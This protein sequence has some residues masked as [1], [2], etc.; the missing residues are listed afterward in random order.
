MRNQF[1]FFDFKFGKNIKFFKVKADKN[2]KS[3]FRLNRFFFVDM[4]FFRVLQNNRFFS[5]LSLNL[6]P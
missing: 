5:S 3:A 4:L 2:T 1:T 6:Q